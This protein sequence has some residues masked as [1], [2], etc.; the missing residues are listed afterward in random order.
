[1]TENVE[2]GALEDKV[3][4]EVYV[5][6][7][8]VQDI[9]VRDAE[10]GVKVYKRAGTTGDP[11]E[12]LSHDGPCLLGG[13]FRH[14]QKTEYGS[15]AAHHPYGGEMARLDATPEREEEAVLLKEIER[16]V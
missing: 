6:R 9:I 12:M 15:I 4:R 3:P 1:M 14:V 16:H 2:Y 10:H 13:D 11:S 8:G 5:Y 7:L